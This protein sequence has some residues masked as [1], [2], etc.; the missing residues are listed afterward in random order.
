DGALPLIRYAIGDHGGVFEYDELLN[1][2]KQHGVDLEAEAKKAGISSTISKKPFVYV[3]ERVDL[4]ASLHGIIIYSEFVK[5]AL[6]KTKLQPYFSQKFTMSTKTDI[7][8]NQFLQINLELQP[9]VEP[10][11]KLKTLS[12]REIVSSLRSKS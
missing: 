2:F 9:D 11:E 7:S 12:Q 4:S 3:Y 1:V 10:N 5:D 8:H 6:L